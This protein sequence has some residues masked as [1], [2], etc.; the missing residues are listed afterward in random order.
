MKL[1]LFLTTSRK[2]RGSRK[3][4]KGRL[5]GISVTLLEAQPEWLPRWFPFPF[6]AIAGTGGGFVSSHVKRTVHR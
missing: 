3:E 2:G 1:K 4:Q 6:H 5:W